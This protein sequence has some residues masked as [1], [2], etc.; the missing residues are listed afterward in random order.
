M[1]FEV[2]LDL[3]KQML[4]F[5]RIE[6]VVKDGQGSDEIILGQGFPG[7]GVGDIGE[8]KTVVGMKFFGFSQKNRADIDAEVIGRTTFATNFAEATMIKKAS[9]V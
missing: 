8:K 7:G 4:V 1:G 6:K 3:G 5:L 9:A 2:G